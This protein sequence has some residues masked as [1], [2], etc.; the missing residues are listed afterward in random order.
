MSDRQRRYIGN[1]ASAGAQLLALINDVLDIAKAK[2]NRFDLQREPLE[3]R[4]ALRAAA[5]Q[6][7]SLATS[8]GIDI[9]LLPGDPAPMVADRRAVHQI[10]LNLLSNAIKFTP[11]GGVLSLG[12]SVGADG[13]V[14]ISVADTGR[15]IAAADLESVFDEYQQVGAEAGDAKGTGLGLALS[16]RL[17]ELMSGTLTVESEV[18]VGST[19][20]LRVPG[21]GVGSAGVRN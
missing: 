16:R 9:F 12:A 20:S 18:G 3:G 8:A 15:G 5:D 21:L 4:G 10:L 13:Y 19:F 6:L 2:A 17:A 14:T 11:S 7:A 1:I